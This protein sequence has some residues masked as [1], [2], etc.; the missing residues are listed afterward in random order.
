MESPRG[1]T[2]SEDVACA[3]C[4]R[5]RV[6]VGPLTFAG[7]IVDEGDFV[8]PKCALK[9]GASAL[10]FATGPQ[11]IATIAYKEGE[12]AATVRHADATDIEEGDVLVM[13]DE[14]G[15]R[16]GTAHVTYVAEQDARR[17]MPTIWER[18][19]Q[20]GLESTDHLLSQLNDQS[21]SPIRLSTQVKTICFE[22]LNI[23]V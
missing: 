4:G 22:V 18:D 14:T 13:R 2:P 19:A 8:C 9:R 7:D 17:A 12:E 21:E 10:T 16:F 1:D 11:T 5:Y 6:L 23:V 3:D 20:Y 15:C